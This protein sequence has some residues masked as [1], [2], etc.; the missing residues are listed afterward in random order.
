MWGDITFPF[1]NFNNFAVEV[2][3]WIMDF[4]QQFA[5]DVISYPCWDETLIH[6]SKN[7]ESLLDQR[8]S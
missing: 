6:V 4:I 8:R 7:G 3:E 1:Q 5:M 2:C